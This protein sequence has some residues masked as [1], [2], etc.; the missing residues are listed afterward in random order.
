MDKQETEH[1]KKNKIIEH[2]QGGGG[3][4]EKKALKRKLV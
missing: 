3:P 4:N 2:N 1:G